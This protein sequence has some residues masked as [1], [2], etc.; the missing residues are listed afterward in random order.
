[1]ER[2]TR[3]GDGGGGFTGSLE[4]LG[5]KKLNRKPGNPRKFSQSSHAAAVCHSLAQIRFHLHPFD[6]IQRRSVIG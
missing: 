1:M 3:D 2:A 6:Q 5:L 4:A